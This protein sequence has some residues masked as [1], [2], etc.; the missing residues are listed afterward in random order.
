MIGNLIKK[1]F[2]EKEKPLTYAIVDWKEEA[3]TFGVTSDKLKEI[4]LIKDRRV[5]ATYDY[6][7]DL[8]EDLEASGIPVIDVTYGNLAP[9]YAKMLP[10]QFLAIGSLQLKTVEYVIGRKWWWK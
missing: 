7:E 2:G 5:V 10:S 4:W 6:D 8:V 9:K 1:I 3:V